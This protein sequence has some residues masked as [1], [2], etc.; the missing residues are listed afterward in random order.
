MRDQEWVKVL[1]NS[2]I[3]SNQLILCQWAQRPINIKILDKLI[4]MRLI[5]A[6]IWM[7]PGL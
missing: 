1:K 3:L 2:S 5:Q 6:F 4:C 7:K